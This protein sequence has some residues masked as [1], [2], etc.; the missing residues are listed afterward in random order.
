M[1][2]LKFNRFCM[3]NFDALPCCN[4]A[5][6]YSEKDCDVYDQRLMVQISL[7]KAACTFAL[8][9]MKRWMKP[10]KVSFISF[11][12]KIK[13]NYLEISKINLLITKFFRCQLLSQLFHHQRKLSQSP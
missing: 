7:A 1:L 11:L 6:K 3:G 12:L 4:S 10:E 13:H 5:N 9:E 8:K 2:F